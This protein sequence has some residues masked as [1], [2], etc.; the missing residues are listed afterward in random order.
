MPARP[1]RTGNLIGCALYLGVVAA[2]LVEIYFSLFFPMA[3]DAC[4]DAACDA[5]YRVG[6][7]MFTLA[8]GVTAV[9]LVTLAGMIVGVRRGR[10]IVG[11]P[12]A[13]LPALGIVYALAVMVLH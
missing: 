7:A 9:L 6:P 5:G 13:A 12:I 3:T 1:A 4:H 11:W 2:G 8:I 10:S